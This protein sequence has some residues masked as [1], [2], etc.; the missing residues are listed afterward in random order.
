MKE[1]EVSRRRARIPVVLA[2]GLGCA[3][4]GSGCAFGPKVLERTH[5]RYNESIRRVY[6]EQLLENLV[7]IRYGESPFRLSVS[8]I[9]AQYELA[10]GAEA[11]PFFLAPNPSGTRF[12]TFTSVLPDV[13]V[14]GANRPTITF[15]P[16]GSDTVRRFLTP[17]SADT[18]VFLAST[19]WPASTVLRLYA[20]RLNGV[21]NAPSASGPQREFAPDFA[22]FQRIA[23]L[24]QVAQD[25]ELIVIAPQERDTTV[26]GP[27]PA[28]SVTA[29]SAVDAAKNGLEYRPSGDGSSWVLVRKEHKLVVEVNPV[30]VDHPVIQELE[31]L[32]NLQPG[33]L[34]Y[35]LVVASDVLDPLRAP[36]PPSTTLRLTPRSTSQVYY[37]LANGVEVP[38]E[39]IATGLIRPPVAPDGMPVDLRAVTAGLFTVH[40]CPGHKPPP[41]A[42]V[43]VKYRGYW[44]YIDDRDQSS[45]TTFALILHLSR[46]DFAAQEGVSGPFLTLPIGR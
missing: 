19:S 33:G 46:L 34:R 14:S 13:T 7:R 23:H 20:E 11:R 40:S 41:H 30:A 44:Y 21:P 2:C 29:A 18:L 24:L 16:S 8:S 10:G 43:A 38:P 15:I 39:H 35:D 42:Y 3:F 12:R 1:T 28:A 5:S 32:L 25:E 27:L 4:A 17:I 37:Y 36:S 22:R 45:K 9:A 26:G 6:E 31:S